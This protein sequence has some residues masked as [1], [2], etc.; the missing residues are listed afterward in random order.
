MTTKYVPPAVLHAC[1][2]TGEKLRALADTFQCAFLGIIGVATLCTYG[3]VL[4]DLTITGSDCDMMAYIPAG[5]AK[6]A[7]IAAL[8]QIADVNNWKLAMP[9]VPGNKAVFTTIEG[10]VLDLTF[11]CVDNIYETQEAW[12][13]VKE[14]ISLPPEMQFMVTAIPKMVHPAYPIGGHTSGIKLVI[15]NSAYVD[16]VMQAIGQ[17]PHAKFTFLLFKLLI[18]S[19]MYDTVPVASTCLAICMLCALNEMFDWIYSGK[20]DIM[21]ILRILMAR[22]LEIMRYVY[23]TEDKDADYWANIHGLIQPG[24]NKYSINFTVVTS[25]Q[26]NKIRGFLGLDPA[27]PVERSMVDLLMKI[28]LLRLEKPANAQELKYYSC[29][30]VVPDLGFSLY[31]ILFANILHVFKPLTFNEEIK[32]LLLNFGNVACWPTHFKLAR[33]CREFYESIQ[34]I[35][36]DKSKNPEFKKQLTHHATACSNFRM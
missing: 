9:F 17:T 34:L 10:L 31:L 29:Y 12:T 26:I 30:W 23:C 7:V 36:I 20:H 15:D 28:N 27:I 13:S 4:H 32:Q 1:V 35:R 5:I 3:S 22:T 6:E 24:V 8:N 16:Y 33:N 19:G 18:N 2:N 25:Y 21:S 11:F 14:G